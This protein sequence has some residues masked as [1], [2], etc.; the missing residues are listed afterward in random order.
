MVLTAAI[1]AS[2]AGYTY[3]RCRHR[4]QSSLSSDRERLLCQKEVKITDF[5][6]ADGGTDKSQTVT[7]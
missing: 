6:D 3:A 1:H 7:D 2:A 4:S 5:I